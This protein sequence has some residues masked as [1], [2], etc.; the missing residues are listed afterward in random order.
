MEKIQFIAKIKKEDKTLNEVLDARDIV[1]PHPS[2]SFYH[3]IYAPLESANKNGVRLATKAVETSLSQLRATQANI[4]HERVAGH[5]SIIDA[6]VTPNDEIEIVVG[7]FKTLFPEEF[8]DVDK[9]AK[10]GKLFVS[11]ELRTDSSTIEKMSDGTRRLHNI[12]WE[13]VGLLL[14]GVAP[15]YSN[16]KTLETASSIVNRIFENKENLIFASAKDV[17]NKIDEIIQGGKD[18]MDKTA[19]DA[20]L[21][22]QKKIVSEEFGELVKDWTDADYLNDEKITALRAEIE[23][24]K[25]AEE[26]KK[27]LCSEC[28]CEL[29]DDEEEICAVC[30]DKKQVKAEEVV[31]VPKEEEAKVFTEEKQVKTDVIVNDDN[32]NI[33]QIIEQKIVVDKVDEVVT[34]VE[35]SITVI[36]YTQQ[37]V[38]EIKSTLEKEKADALLAKDTEIAELQKQKVEVENKLKVISLRQELGKYIE[39]LSDEQ[40]LADESLVKAARDQKEAEAK[41]LEVA[42]SQSESMT[43]QTKSEVNADKSEEELDKTECMKAYVQ[44]QFRIK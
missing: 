37:Q 5:G 36:T 22:A 15:A 8:I 28:E 16:A 1:H 42:S 25:K 9:A 19:N 39:S 4:N 10:D 35:E 7:F 20:L 2:L 24:K 43:A 41:T 38:D 3:F 21:A 26:P 11:F 32:G 40:L 30:K 23:A 31:E 12:E 29:K 33:E 27:R 14:P 44:K 6:W 18:E 13:G 34:R 17:V